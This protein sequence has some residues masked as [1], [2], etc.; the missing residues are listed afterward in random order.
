MSDERVDKAWQKTGLEKYSTAAILGTLQHYGVSVD[1]PGFTAAAKEKFPLEI[2]QDWHVAWK[3]TGQF[4]RYP[5][6]ACTELWRRVNPDRLAPHELALAVFELMRALKQLLEGSPNAPVGP[7]FEK[8]N[9][10]KAKVPLKEGVLA[11]SFVGELTM[12]MT[13]AMNDFNQLGLDLAKDGHEEDAEAFVKLEEFLFP[14]WKGIT[15]A[16]M[17]AQQGEQVQA[18][19]DLE[20]IARDTTR[21]GDSRMSALD[22]L[23]AL[24]AQEPAKEI[25]RALFEDGQK[26]KDLHLALAAGERLVSLMSQ[27]GDTQGMEELYGQLQALQQAHDAA[28]DHSHE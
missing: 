1:E 7:A 21:Q 14:A 27:S 19:K 9:G 2:A 25:A 4:A 22:A 28:H 15:R 6:A 8:V 13:E 23:I 26:A 5:W 12:H 17:R 16:M 11:P 10:L 3:G 18:A 20:A 24:D